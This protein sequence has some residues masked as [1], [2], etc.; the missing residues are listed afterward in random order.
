MTVRQNRPGGKLKE[1]VKMD[2]ENNAIEGAPMPT[3]F[4]PRASWNRDFREVTVLTKNCDYSVESTPAPLPL[5]LLIEKQPPTTERS[6][7]E[8]CPKYVGFIISNAGRSA[9]R[10]I[11][12]DGEVNIQELF[13]RLAKEFP[14][15]IQYL[16]IARGI[17]REHGVETV[18][19]F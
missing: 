2:Q 11:G 16:D 5:S 12:I 10:K 1:G 14:K 7:T 3:K 19:M 15:G 6:E 13:D 18:K 17:A 4:R 9:I 8:T